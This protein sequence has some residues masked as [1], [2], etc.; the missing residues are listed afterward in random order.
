[1]NSLQLPNSPV[2]GAAA[3]MRREALAQPPIRV[4]ANTHGVRQFAHQGLRWTVRSGAEAVVQRLPA[5]AWSQ[6]QQ[7]GWALV[8]Q[9]AARE[10]W[11][12][13]IGERAYYLKYYAGGSWRAALKR[14]FGSDACRDEW[15]GGLFALRNGIPAAVPVAHTRVQR[16]R[17]TWGLLITE[18]VEPAYPLDAFWSTIAG[19]PDVRRRR[20]DTR[21]VAELLGQLIARA[22]Q[23][24]FEHL[25]MHAANILVQPVAPGRY[26][27]L[28]IDLHSARRDRPISDAAIVRNLAQLNQWFSKHSS[29]A[30][31]LRFLR[32]YFRWRN[33]YEHA[34]AHARSITGSFR[35]L[36]CALAA[37]ARLHAERL[38]AQRDRRMRRSG[39]Y[40]ACLRLGGGWRGVACITSKHAV[41]E[42]R[43]SARVLTRQWWRECL[44]RPE[45]LSGG[46]HR[47]KDSHSAQV[48]RRELA[49]PEGALRVIV[50]RPLA[51][52]GWRRLRGML[53]ISRARRGFE[54]GHMLLHRDLAA[55]RPLALLER[56]RG[57]VLLDSMLMTEA[58][59]GALDLPQ[60]LRQEF[61]ARPP[62]AWLA[63][64]RQLA[65]LLVRHMRRLHDRGFVHRDCKAE[66]ILVLPAPLTLM[67]IDMDGLRHRRPARRDELRA[68][69]RLHVSLLGLA[70]LT[71]TD[72]VRFLRD[73]CSRFGGR[74]DQ[75][76]AVWR[77]LEQ[78]VSQKLTARARRREWK[79][80]HYGRE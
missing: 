10:V 42:S 12:A 77:A 13:E 49:H 2:H 65:Q 28:F 32:A 19:D 69:A 30:D 41:E 40:F 3:V 15:A 7:Q 71:R 44:A 16:E 80:A 74:V 1:M 62:P 23:A 5:G 46:E 76:R 8:K 34:F 20:S 75:W 79:L 6:P 4:E 11:R 55:A 18:A 33:E 57:G 43:A 35:E 47:M 52:N 17:G 36:F 31:R 56:R 39:R 59:D 64:K 78:H 14:A 37:A 60:Y 38:W 21:Q 48:W 58:V 24:G 73:Y 53:G 50:K 51:R 63:T 70:G 61:G 45:Q 9:N 68:L 22:H 29:T 25:D 26:Q 72:R 54:L 67:W 66:N 27:A